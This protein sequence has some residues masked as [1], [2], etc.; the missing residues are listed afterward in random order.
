MFQD[1]QAKAALREV[2]GFPPILELLKSEYA[3]I[4]HL[5]LVSLQRA[6]EDG[7]DFF[8]ASALTKEISHLPNVLLFFVFLNNLLKM[9]PWI[10]FS[11]E[12]RVVLRELEAMNRLIDF[13]GHPEWSDMHVFA[14]M[15]IS[16]CLE[17]PESIE[18]GN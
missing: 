14:V 18:V 7:E 13:I 1:Y 8:Y 15:V 12:N 10:Y 4:Q 6:A 9:S 5:S 11:A 16:N 17:D 2:N 3:V